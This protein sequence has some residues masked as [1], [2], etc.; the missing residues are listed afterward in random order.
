MTTAVMPARRQTDDGDGSDRRRG[1]RTEAQWDA[2]SVDNEH[3]STHLWIVNRGIDLLAKHA[4]E[5]P[6]AKRAVELLNT[7]SCRSNWQQGLLDADFKA[8][9]NNGRSDLQLNASDVEVA[10]SGAT[11]ESHFYDADTGKN[12]KGATSPTALTEAESHIQRSME[13]GGRLAA[14]N[15]KSCYELGLAF[16]YFTDLTQPMHASNF[17]AVDRPAKLHSNLEGYALEIQDR[18]PLADWSGAPSGEVHDFIVKTA[19]DSKALF[20]PG[21]KAVVNAYNRNKWAHGV[22]CRDIE[23]DPLRFIERQHVDYKVC[24]A[25]DAE[26]DA[27][28]GNS[29]HA[30]QDHTAEFIYLVVSKGL[31]SGSS[32]TES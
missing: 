19:K 9:Y 18:F 25:G 8:V 29:L 14:D 17:T 2:E 7:P 31:G 23:V 5:L 22:L 20:A 26:V 1:E 4:D 3:A 16:H 24:W 15:A 10:L 6:I 11:W 30:A 27:A 32:A 28:V 21:V 12:Y 13:D